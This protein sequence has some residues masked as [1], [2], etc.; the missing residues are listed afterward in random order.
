MFFIFTIY[1]MIFLAIVSLNL[2]KLH[3]KRYANLTIFRWSEAKYGVTIFF[4][5]I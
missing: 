1:F 2:I 5:I 3:S 4:T